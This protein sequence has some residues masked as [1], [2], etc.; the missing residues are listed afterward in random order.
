[1]ELQYPVQPFV[2]EFAKE[3]SKNLRFNDLHVRQPP[4]V[5]LEPVN[6]YMENNGGLLDEFALSNEKNN[7]G[8]L[9][10]V[11]QCQVNDVFFRSDFD[12]RKSEIFNKVFPENCLRHRLFAEQLVLQLDVVQTLLY[13]SSNQQ[14]LRFFNSFSAIHKINTQLSSVIPQVNTMK[15]DLRTLDEVTISTIQI[16]G[17]KR[18]QERL[19]EIGNMIASMSKIKMAHSAS[20]SLAEQGDFAGSFQLV[21]ET[22]KELSDHYLGIKALRGFL[23]RLREVRNQIA[24]KAILAFHQ[25]FQSDQ[26]TS[27]AIIGTLKEYGLLDDALNQASAYIT[28]YAIKSIK[29]L[30]SESS[31]Q[32]GFKDE[33]VF[34]LSV[35]NFNEVLSTVFPSIRNRILLKNIDS[36]ERIAVE[37]NNQGL[38]SSKLST[39]SAQLAN[40]LFNEVSTVVS[41]HPLKGAE[42]DDFAALYD[43]MIS[44]GRNVEKY[45]DKSKLQ[46]ALGTLCR[47]FVESFSNEQFEYLIETLNHEKWVKKSPESIH[48]DILHKLTGESITELTI[49]GEKFGSTASLLFLLEIIWNYFQ[50]L[51]KITKTAEEIAGKLTATIKLFGEKNISLLIK[52]ESLRLATL[53][54]ISTKNLALAAAGLAFLLKLFPYLKPRL[55]AFLIDQGV[56]ERLSKE[57]ENQLNSQLNVFIRKIAEVMENILKAVFNRIE[58]NPDEPSQYVITI[59]NEVV[60]LNKVISD[61][62]PS[63]I[64]EQINKSIISN[65]NSGLTKVFNSARGSKNEQLFS[66]DIDYLNERLQNTQIQVKIPGLAK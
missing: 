61:C 56:V 64:V 46:V 7:S 18:Q 24:S 20:I 35:K 54:Q 19:H 38:D 63:I 10:T 53:K 8:A 39:L 60:T 43:L 16:S 48:I 9:A 66:R 55:L 47:S 50:A 36:F 26:Y 27:L 23:K 2:F 4:A 28:S 58:F 11:E 17:L 21:D 49:N 37:F 25:L 6:Q 33:Q 22:I 57:V 32:K 13:Q 41:S 65:I 12:L 14:V 15:S 44:F 42:L 34:N 1:M 45:I 5:D 62:L 31:E 59:S 51:R 3:A 30:I 40:D 52:G 29:K